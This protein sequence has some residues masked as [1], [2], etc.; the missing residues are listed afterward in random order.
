MS[1]ARQWD[2]WDLAALVPVLEREVG[3]DG[4]TGSAA[5]PTEEGV[6]FTTEPT[7]AFPTADVAHVGRNGSRWSVTVRLP[8]LY[9]VA[10]VLPRAD[11][12]ALIQADRRGRDATR[13]FLQAL[14]QRSL[15]L[16][17]RAV[18]RHA[19]ELLD[20]AWS[21]LATAVASYG[22]LARAGAIPRTP[23]LL[24]FVAGLRRP[25]GSA[26]SIERALRRA[27]G[28]AVRVSV[29]SGGR[30]EL[31]A[32]DRT[33]LGHANHRLGRTTILGARAATEPALRVSLQADSR[34]MFL[35]LQPGAA[36]FDLAHEVV[37]RVAGPMVDV[38]WQLTLARPDI[39]ALVLGAR[40]ALARDAWL[41]PAADRESV[42][43]RLRSARS[44]SW[45]RARERSTH[46]G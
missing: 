13:A 11:T 15:A 3:K 36:R 25:S 7:L 44:G 23:S 32:A 43:V 6:W 42:T 10:G 29:E 19:G 8:G 35:D 16:F 4:T 46:A 5:R 31:H 41:R 28:I 37:R 21:E 27:L 1:T 14:Q 39:P 26:G 18:R 12:E 20:G 38:I 17:Y 33:R 45:L 22:G 9:G 24:P 30:A 2:A 34:E 40:R